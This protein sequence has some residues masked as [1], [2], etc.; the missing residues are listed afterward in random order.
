MRTTF[1]THGFGNWSEPA[2]PARL[3][4]RNAVILILLA[5][6]FM[7]GTAIAAAYD[8]LSDIDARGVMDR[9]W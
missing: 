2:G 5:L 7:W 4:R 3:R 9:P 1:D 8:A 6:G